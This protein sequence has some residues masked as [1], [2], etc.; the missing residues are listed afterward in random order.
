MDMNNLKNMM[1]SFMENAQ[2]LQENMKDKVVTGRAGGDLVVVDANLKMQITRLEL[3]PSLFEE[4][5]EVIT[6]LVM[7]AVNQALQNAQQMLKQ[8]IGGKFGL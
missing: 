8:E 2:K 7:G 3:A 5:P 6:E 1:S 4:K